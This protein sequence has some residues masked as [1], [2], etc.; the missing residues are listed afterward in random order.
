M[1]ILKCLDLLALRLTDP[2]LSPFVT[3]VRD[4]V[5]VGTSLSD[6]FARQGVFPPIYNTTILA[7][8]KSGSLTEVLERY[9][10]YQRM[11]LT[12]KKKLLVSLL[13]PCLL[14]VLVLLLVVFLV[15]YVVPQFAQLYNSMDA[16]LP[17]LTTLLI[18]IGTTAQ[19][20][21]W[22]FLGGAV[23]IGVGLRFWLKTKSAKESLER[24]QMRIPVAGEIW[25]KYQVAQFARVLSTLLLGG[26]PL[27][28]ALETAGE[29]VGTV[30][31]SK[32]L[33]DVRRSVREGKPLASSLK[34]T[35]VFPELSIDMIEVGESSG[36]LP[37]MLS[38]V[39]EFYDEDVQ[40]RL[41]AALSLIEPA[42]MIFMGMFV[43][44]VLV[45]LYLAHLFVG[46]FDWRIDYGDATDTNSTRNGPAGRTRSRGGGGAG[47]GGALSLRIC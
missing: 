39:A 21:I 44:F 17:Y 28:Q 38:S 45:A 34:S 29:S 16:K 11:T 3:A 32:A 2:K 47:V 41:A 14:I 27:I 12:V 20:Y 24:L 19:E 6:A 10:N 43:A 33:D 18:S 5:K 36:A 35:G 25:I 1:P 7:G 22:Y 31:L 26:I 4:D 40:N 46:R 9:I 42:I 13:Y 8:E 15:S 37:A 30:V 23:A